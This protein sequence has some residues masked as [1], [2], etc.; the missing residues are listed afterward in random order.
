MGVVQ[1]FKTWLTHPLA[2]GLDLDDPSTTVVRRRII[3]EKAIL[4]LVYEEWYRLIVE[5]LPKGDAPILELGSGGG[6]L[7]EL[8]PDLI[9]TD[10]LHVPFISAVAD[11]HE[12]PFRSGSLGSVVMVNVLHHLAG[13]RRFFEEAARCVQT[14]GRI[15]MIE[16]WVTRWSSFVFGRLHHEP[17][18][19]Q[20]RRWDF[21]STGPLSGANG[22]LPW[23]LFQRD[24]DL[25]ERI[26]PQWRI[27]SIRLGMPFRYL[28][29][30]GVSLR[31]LVPTWSYGI[32]T[33]LE[34]VI[35]RYTENMAMFAHVVLVRQPDPPVEMQAPREGI[36]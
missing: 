33:R 16:P 24:R 11:A 12:L 31:A 26:L 17:F 7:G 5:S 9:A 25:F 22:A 10:I 23:I 27:E 20:A 8:L 4:R 29:S 30:G 15:V 2:R 21:P 14:G 32:L 13:P 18:D 19:P 1:R 36:A 3:K 28:L 35:G 34:D 6:F